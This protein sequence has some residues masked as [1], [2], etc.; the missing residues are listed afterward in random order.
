MGRSPDISRSGTS[1]LVSGV[2]VSESISAAAVRIFCTLP[3]S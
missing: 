3:G 2:A 1:T